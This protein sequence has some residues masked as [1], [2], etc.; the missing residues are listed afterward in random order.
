VTPGGSVSFGNPSARIVDAPIG[1][2]TVMWVSY[3]L[4]AE[5]A[6]AGEAGSLIY[7]IDI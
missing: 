6:G 5:G 7:W 1:A 2:G 3:F 4:F